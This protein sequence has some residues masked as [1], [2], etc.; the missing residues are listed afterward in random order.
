MDYLKKYKYL[1]RE[2]YKK[3]SIIRIELNYKFYLNVLTS[4][5][6]IILH[7]I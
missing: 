1:I 6:R 4:Y 3:K 5:K 2:I 7:N